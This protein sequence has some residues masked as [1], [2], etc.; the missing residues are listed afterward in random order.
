MTPFVLS[1]ILVVLAICT[2]LLSFQL[3]ERKQVI[4]CLLISCGLISSH[5]ALL[6]QWTATSLGVLA[7]ARF[8][9]SYNNP[10][11]AVMWI[12]ILLSCI[13][14][15]FTWGGYLSLLTCLGSIFGTAA[16]FSRSDRGL[17][18]LMMVGTS[19]WILNNI[20][21][22]SPLAVF[23]ESI[24]LASNLVGFYRFYLSPKR[25]ALS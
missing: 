25:L 3:K 24:F 15:A 8:I 9:L 13:I 1:Q 18:L 22:G 16:A 23:L 7:G 2:D 10:S 20:L 17:R 6:E 11:K 14:A 19:F 5:F 4:I 12:F 21:V